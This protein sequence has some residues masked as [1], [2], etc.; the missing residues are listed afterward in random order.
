MP[1]RGGI[2][3]TAWPETNRM[4]LTPRETVQVEVALSRRPD[5][6][7][8]M[9]DTERG[10]PYRAPAP[11]VY[12]EGSATTAELGGLYKLAV[13]RADTLVVA[14]EALKLLHRNRRLLSP[15]E[16][17]YLGELGQRLNEQYNLD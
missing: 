7:D 3:W 14:R 12:M 1:L 15:A 10:G 13:S 9:T 11:E 4:E 2:D 6:R 17:E 16:R 8:G 5:P